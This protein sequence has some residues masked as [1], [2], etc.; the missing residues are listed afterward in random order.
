MVGGEPEKSP[1]SHWDLLV[2][3]VVMV[4]SRVGGESEKATNE[5]LGLI[6]G[7]SVGSR[8]DREPEKPPTSHWDSLVVM[9][10]CMAVFYRVDYKSLVS[11]FY[12]K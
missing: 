8:G 12:I 7:G 10:G 1:T 5:S 11:N 4:E 2:V 9:V 3:V 6:C